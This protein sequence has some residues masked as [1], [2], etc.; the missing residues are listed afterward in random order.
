MRTAIVI[1]TYNERENV[2]TLIPRLFDLG[3]PDLSVVVVDDSSPDGTADA[4]RELARRYPTLYLISRPR[5]E[6]LGPAYRSGFRFVLEAGAE[7]IIQMDADLSHP[8]EDVPRLV[9]AVETGAE[10]AVGSR[11]VPGGAMRIEW[12]RRAISRWGNWYAQRVLGT[13]I[14]DLT[15][16]FKCF[17]RSALESV[18]FEHVDAIG[19]VFQVEMTWRMLRAGARVVEVPFVF[20]ERRSGSSKFSVAIILESVWKVWRM[21]R[22]KKL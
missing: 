14:T 21:R 19:Y 12:Y 11:Y 5:K 4:V 10:L 2:G 6:G 17:R 18:D 20:I 8:P 13:R 16:G 1:P 7:T 9:T 22:G 15:S 3:V